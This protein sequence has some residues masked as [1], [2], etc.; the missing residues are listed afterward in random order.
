MYQSKDGILRDP[1]DK[2]Y[3][4]RMHE[5]MQTGKARRLMKLRQGTVEPVIGRLINYLGMKKVNTKGIAQANKCMTMAA[6]AYNLKK[7]L[8]YAGGPKVVA[9]AQAL[10]TKLEHYYSNLL[11]N[12][13]HTTD[14]CIVYYHNIK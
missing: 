14:H 12:I 2:I 4:S 8:R 9:K 11:K 3:Y 5:R 1:I 13:F 6:T 10:I 7:L